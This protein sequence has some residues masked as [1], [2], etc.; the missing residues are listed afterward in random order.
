MG[1]PWPLEFETLVLT[2]PVSQQNSS[3]LLASWLYDCVNHHEDCCHQPRVESVLPLR[4]LDIGSLVSPQ[5][6]FLSVGEVG[7]DRIGSYA[8]LK[9]LLGQ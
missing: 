5:A 6:I 7:E 2:I 8:A 1:D 9:L 4:I 3:I